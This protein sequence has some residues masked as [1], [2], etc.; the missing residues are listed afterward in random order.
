MKLDAQPGKGAGAAR[1]EGGFRPA[2]KQERMPNAPR[3]AGAA[4]PSGQSAMAAAF[5]KLQTKR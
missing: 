1:G 5:A 2:G 3:G 4:Q